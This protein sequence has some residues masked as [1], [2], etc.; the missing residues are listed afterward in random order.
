MVRVWDAGVSE[1]ECG[2]SGGSIILIIGSI[3]RGKKI[4]RDEK[5]KNLAWQS[6]VWA[7]ALL[8]SHLR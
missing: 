5:N 6:V 8:V 1:A 3:E 4:I 7:S 2:V